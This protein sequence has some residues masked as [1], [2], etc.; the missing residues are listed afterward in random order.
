MKTLL[1]SFLLLGATDK[2]SEV[3]VGDF[4]LGAGVI[5]LG[6]FIRSVETE[7]KWKKKVGELEAEL[8]VL[9]AGQG[10]TQMCEGCRQQPASFMVGDGAEAQMLCQ[11]CIS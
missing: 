10:N 2:G 9:R 3:D 7:E 1:M 8:Q 6:A 5:G 11:G 4:L